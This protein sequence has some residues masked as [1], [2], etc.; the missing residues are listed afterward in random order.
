M[1]VAIVDTFDNDD[2]E[3]E[4]SSVRFGNAVDLTTASFFS[5][6]AICSR[7]SVLQNAMTTIISQR[8]SYIPTLLKFFNLA[9]PKTLPHVSFQTHVIV[10]SLIFIIVVN[11]I[12]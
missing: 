2:I 11:K 9:S 5:F 1:H 7:E 12:N 8:R 6:L 4:E 10:S 3:D